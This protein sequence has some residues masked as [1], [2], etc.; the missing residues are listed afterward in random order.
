MPP[1]PMVTNVVL[2]WASRAEAPVMATARLRTAASKCLCMSLSPFC[3][4]FLVNYMKKGF[5]AREVFM[6]SGILEVYIFVK[7]AVSFR[8]GNRFRDMGQWFR[9]N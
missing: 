3:R 4:H 7:R 8:E 5:K 1:V 9:E 2:A 6:V